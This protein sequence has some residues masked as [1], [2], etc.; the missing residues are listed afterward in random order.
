MKIKT[1]SL[2]FTCWLALLCASAAYAAQEG[3]QAPGFNLRDL[4]GGTITLEQFKGKVVFLDFWA[5]WCVPCRDEL[6]ELERLYKKYENKGFIVVGIAVDASTEGVTKFLQKV[7]VSFPVLLDT[8]G[9][10]AEAY[11]LVN[12]PTAYL[13]GRDGVMR[14][15]YKGFGKDLL[16]LYE[17]KISELLEQ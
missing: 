1:P 4:T 17:N 10:V 12:M 6:P 9:T 15:V 11:R 3:A 14:H 2:I 8:K 13:I 5:P 7:P 16:T